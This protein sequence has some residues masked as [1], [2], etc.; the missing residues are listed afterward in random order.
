MAATEPTRALNIRDEAPKPFEEMGAPG[1]AIYGGY[2]IEA[3]K[4]SSLQGR[5]K[6]TTYSDI[7]ANTSIVAAGVR[8]FL[9]LVSK[10]GWK[11]EPADDS[12]EAE[13]YAELVEEIIEDM[14]TPWHR[15][16]RRAA[17]YRFY[18][19]SLQEWTAKR[20]EDGTVG[21]LDIEPRPQVTIDQWDVDRKGKVLGVVQRDPYDGQDLYLPR[22]KLVYLCDDSLNDSPEGLGLFRHLAKTA[23]RLEKY[24]LLE[25]WG[26]ETD[27]RGIPL[28]R[29]PLA[30]IEDLMKQGKLSKEQAAALRKP[31]EDFID[32]HSKNPAMGLLMDSSVY[33]AEGELKTPS[34]T[35]LWAA[36][37]LKGDNGPHA[38]IAKAIERLNRE[39]AR[40]LGVEHLLLGSDSKGSHALATDKTQS[41][42]MIV[43]STLTEMREQFRKDILGPIWELNG[44]PTEMMPR[45]MTESIQYRDVGQI[46]EALKGLAAAGAPLAV[47]DPA[48]NE[49]RA[50]IGLTDAPE[51]DLTVPLP[52]EMPPGT[53][54]NQ[55]PNGD[56]MP[57]PEE[58]EL[59][60]PEDGEGEEA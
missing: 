35:P 58:P 12:A 14:D 40:V 59:E 3:E 9:N 19:F 47:N 7:L 13:K 26:F 21:M 10:A 5:Q 27:L 50:Q 55:P 1:T 28:V 53:D 30:R 8:F 43:D 11:V 38:D 2:I 39:L 42:G 48:I 45:F 57:E 17:M 29:I 16:V 31:F 25:S 34:A 51:Q 18:G 33:R 41:F 36:E 15:V 44:W 60:E 24:E 49:V 20:R 46:V 22:V 52:G 54:P 4:D 23:K 32:K 56:E 6:Y 37:L